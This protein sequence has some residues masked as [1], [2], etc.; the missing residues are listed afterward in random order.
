MLIDAPGIR[1]QLHRMVSRLGPPFLREDLMQEA[2][3]HLWQMEEQDPSK[4]QGWYL[5]GCRFYLQNFL[6]Q[7]R[8]VDSVKHFRAQILNR[9]QPD[10]GLNLFDPAQSNTSM[11][12]EGNVNDCMAEL[13]QWLTPQ[14]NDTLLCLMDGLSARETAKRLDISHTMVNRHRA[15]IAN[16]ALKLGIA[17]SRPRSKA[18]AREAHDN[19][20]AGE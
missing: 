7:G 6:R 19:P 18:R 13:F 20:V 10:D 12:E 14:E 9:E 2:L 17:P 3:V 11:W 8:S 15:Q 4:D 5:Q 16:L 1:S